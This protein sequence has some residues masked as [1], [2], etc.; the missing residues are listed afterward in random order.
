MSAGRISSAQVVSLSVMV[1]MRNRC[2]TVSGSGT[3][4]PG[5]AA[6]VLVTALP[7]QRH[8]L[9]KFTYPMRRGAGWRRR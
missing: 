2:A 9:L 6:I 3:P 8:D 1:S 4:A 7:K 5:T